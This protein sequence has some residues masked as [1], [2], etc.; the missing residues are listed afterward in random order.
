M[1]T[2]ARGTNFELVVDA[3]VL[4]KIMK[5]YREHFPVLVSGYLLGLDRENKLEITSC[6]ETPA[7]TDEDERE[8][9]IAKYQDDML[10]VLEEV[11]GDNNIIGWYQCVYLGS[12][13]R[14]P[15]MIETQCEYQEL[16]EKA[17]VLVYDPQQT[18]VGKFPFRA[19]RVSDAFMRR[20]RTAQSAQP[21]KPLDLHSMTAADVLEEVPLKLRNT[22]LMEA[23]LSTWALPTADREQAL[24]T[25]LKLNNQQF[26]EKHVSLLTQAVDDLQSEQVKMQGYERN[27]FRMQMRKARGE[28]ADDRKAVAPSQLDSMLISSQ[29][30]SYCKQLEAHAGGSMGKMMLLK[31]AAHNDREAKE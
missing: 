27:L 13:L 5:H 29:V 16:I 17:V 6:F 4:L 25:G 22:F 7:K 11:H 30:G 19:L 14:D 26:L 12:Y 23:F 10:K 15:T 1:A 21:P 2:F 3:M 9:D 31:K 24:F 20:R 28:A 18:S 8:H